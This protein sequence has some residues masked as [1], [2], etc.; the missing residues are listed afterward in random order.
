MAVGAKKSVAFIIFRKCTQEE[1]LKFD[2]YCQLLYCTVYSR[3]SPFI[4]NSKPAYCQ[5]YIWK[6]SLKLAYFKRCIDW[7]KIKFL[8]RA[9]NLT[10]LS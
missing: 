3:G 9:K 10:Q 5:S 2:I 1:I 6:Y 7:P 8:K 4:L